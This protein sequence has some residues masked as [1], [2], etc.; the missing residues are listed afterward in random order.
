MINNAVSIDELRS[1]LSEFIG[2]VMYGKDRVIIKKYNREAA[3]LLSLD[4]YEKLM[5]PTKRLSKS[6]W[7]KAV[8]KLDGIRAKIP[9][10]DQEILEKE[11]IFEGSKYLEYS[12]V[13]VEKL[14]TEIQFD[15][16][17]KFED[18]KEYFKRFKGTL[19]GSKLETEIAPLILLEVVEK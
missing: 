12:K 19:K 7:G 6:Q 18:G 5:D 14:N 15:L 1:N 17:I 11:K 10:V 9:K 16:R 4:E 3:V 8:Q 2:R 13:D